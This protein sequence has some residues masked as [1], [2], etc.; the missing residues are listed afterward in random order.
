[1]M[2]GFTVHL[3]VFLYLFRSFLFCCLLLSSR[4]T[5][6]SSG[7][8]SYVGMYGSQCSRSGVCIAFEGRD[9]RYG[10]LN[11]DRILSKLLQGLC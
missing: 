9:T 4:I 6:Q 11:T 2:S 10:C 5:A 7:M 1:M 3:S 8:N